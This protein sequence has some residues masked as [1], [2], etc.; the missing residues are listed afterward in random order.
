MLHFPAL[1][2]LR[3][4]P[5]GA[6]PDTTLP[7]AW[8]GRRR[9]PP[10]TLDVASAL[11][12]PRRISRA[13]VRSDLLVAA[14]AATLRAMGYDLPTAAI[15]QD[16]WTH[17]SR[18]SRSCLSRRSPALQPMVYVPAVAPHALR[19]GAVSWPPP[20]RPRDAAGARG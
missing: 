1:F 20:D 4:R 14:C 17:A 6:P 2:F 18:A 7:V 16:A 13:S 5:C 9:N 10:P 12:A 11:R 8:V 19:P 15:Y 3:P